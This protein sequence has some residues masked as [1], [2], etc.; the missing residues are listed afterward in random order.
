MISLR[1]DGAFFVEERKRG[2]AIRE[3]LPEEK[4]EV[5][6]GEQGEVLSEGRLFVVFWG[7]V[8]L[9]MQCF[10][11]VEFFICVFSLYKKRFVW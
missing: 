10:N 3:F 5:F 9:P 11:E 8:V 2:F 6:F 7:K 1:T 4:S